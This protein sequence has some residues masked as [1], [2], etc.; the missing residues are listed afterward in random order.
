MRRP[1][2]YFLQSFGTQGK[3]LEEGHFIALSL[4][5]AGRWT[6]SMEN[7][8]C[9]AMGLRITIESAARKAILISPSE[10][11]KGRHRPITAIFAA[12]LIV[13]TQLVGTSHYHHLP[14]S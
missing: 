4:T 10:I 2:A 11:V 13:F 3:R 7:L 8:S 9:T 1:T 5:W 14:S 6:R 12:A